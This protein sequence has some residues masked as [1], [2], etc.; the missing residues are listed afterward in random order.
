MTELLEVKAKF[1]LPDD[2]LA[3]SAAGCVG[4]AAEP[5]LATFDKTASATCGCH[6]S[7]PAPSSP[8]NDASFEQM[9]QMIT[10]QIMAANR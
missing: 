2:R 8:A 5:F 7:A 1:G 9:V 4:E 10:D 6:E 3:C